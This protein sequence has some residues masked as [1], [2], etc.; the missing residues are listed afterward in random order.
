MAAVPSLDN[1]LGVFYIAAVTSGSLWGVSCLQTFS[2]FNSYPNDPTWMRLLVIGTWSMD[3][4]H[5]I[6]VS[7]G[8]YIGLVTNWGNLASLGV[9]VWSVLAQILAV[10]AFVVQMFFVYRVWKLS[11][12]NPYMTVPVAV[13]AVG[14]LIGYCV[15][16]GK[17]Y[18]GHFNTYLQLSTLK[19]FDIGLNVVTAATDVA[20][21]AVISYLL[22]RS[23]TGFRRFTVNTGLL[24]S[25]NALCSLIA[26]AVSPDTFIYVFF[27]FIM[28][29]LY[30][31]SLLAT[32]NARRSVRDGSSRGESHSLQSVPVSGG[33]SAA[34]MPPGQPTQSL[35]VKVDTVLEYTQ[36]SDFERRND[37]HKI[38]L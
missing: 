14:E 23:R 7:H 8:V 10:M 38:R 33:R 22:N 16:C 5:Q 2:Y 6:L 3:T 11:N 24:T 35:S 36:D 29:R 30:T 18:S 19:N 13:M 31:N 1:T 27:F 28:A 12:R 21:A 17:V 4:L 25:V 20:I 37:D 26:V 15:Y 34:I 9:V 32:L